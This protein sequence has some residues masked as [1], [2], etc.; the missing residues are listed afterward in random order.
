MPLATASLPTSSDNNFD[1]KSP[2]MSS[3]A[4][5]STEP[6]VAPL[7][8]RQ[9]ELAEAELRARDGGD[10]LRKWVTKMAFR[11][12]SMHVIRVAYPSYV[13]ERVPERIVEFE[14]CL[15]IHAAVVRSTLLGET[16]DVQPTFTGVRPY[17][18]T[19]TQIDW[20]RGKH[21]DNDE[22]LERMCVDFYFQFET[23]TG[24]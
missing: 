9:R 6:T 14:A 3:P 5:T 11:A 15:A 4:I 1:R 17:G 22:T 12:A 2:T 20:L 18:S 10:W 24:Q 23:T 19:P 8:G 21:P 7:T 16:V 13:Y